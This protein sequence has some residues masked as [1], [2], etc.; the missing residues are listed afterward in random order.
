MKQ[1]KYKI[2]T[3]DDGTI[4]AGQTL[5][6]I[7]E[8]ARA[9]HDAETRSLADNTLAL[10]DRAFVMIQCTKEYLAK[11]ESKLSV[12]LAYGNIENAKRIYRVLVDA[13]TSLVFARNKL[14]DEMQWQKLL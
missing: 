4:M 13:C 14:N 7:S 9:D 8:Q 10:I 3:L 6:T 12:E 5:K 2:V 11:L 1:P